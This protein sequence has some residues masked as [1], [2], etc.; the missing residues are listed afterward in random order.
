MAVDDLN[1]VLLLHMNGDDNGTIFTDESGKTIGRSGNVVT[2]TGQKKFGSASA[3]FDGNSDYLSISGIV[4]GTG[5]FTID[6]WF[7][8]TGSTGLPISYGGS[9]GGFVIYCHTSATGIWANGNRISAGGT[10]LNTWHHCAVVGNGAADGSR[11]IKMYMDG[12]LIGTWTT[13]YNYSKTVLVSECMQGYIDEVRISNIERW[14]T[15]FIP[16]LGEYTA[17]TFKTSGSVVFGPFALPMLIADPASSSIDWTEDVPEDT[18]LTVKTAIVSGTPAAEDYQAVINGDPIPGLDADSSELNLYIKAELVTTDTTK[19]PAL[20]AMS[21]EIVEAQNDCKLVVK[22]TYDGRM[23]HPQGDVTL[24]FTGMLLGVAGSAVEAFTLPFTP[25][26]LTLFFN[27]HDLEYTQL[28]DLGLTKADLLPVY[29]RSYQS[30]LDY[31]EIVDLSLL[32]A[33]L[34]HIDDL[35]E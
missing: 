19:T 2:K 35:S 26:G 6:F 28:A 4:F 30:A 31:T 24:A 25:T 22:L 20:S 13:N 9:N 12:S 33:V 5:A 23:K 34:T 27:P 14:T 1:T 7:Y 15:N 29:Y 11:N 16:P 32:S 10:S 21:F 17:T 18:S 8:R 3:L